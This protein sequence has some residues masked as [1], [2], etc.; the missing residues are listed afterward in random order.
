MSTTQRTEEGLVSYYERLNDNKTR[1]V[2]TGND[3]P[4]DSDQVQDF[5]AGLHNSVFGEWKTMYHI[6]VAEGTRKKYVNVEAAYQGVSSYVQT[7]IKTGAL[8]S[9]PGSG[10]R[11]NTYTAFTINSS[12]APVRQ[13]PKDQ[14][15]GG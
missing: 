14:P 15:S 3:M 6:G 4:S 12:G 13:Q 7:M 5:L 10:A 11:G 8:K 9:M 1:M 2:E